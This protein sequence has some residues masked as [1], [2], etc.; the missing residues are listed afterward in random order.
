MSQTIRAQMRASEQLRKEKGSEE[1]RGR[2][3]REGGAAGMDKRHP[4][5]PPNFQVTTFEELYGEK[6]E[7]RSPTFHVSN[8]EASE[9]SQGWREAVEEMKGK[10]EEQMREVKEL[11]KKISQL[12]IESALNKQEIVKREA[13]KT[14]QEVG[15]VMIAIM[16]SKE[17]MREAR[18]KSDAE[19]LTNEVRGKRRGQQME[20]LLEEMRRRNEEEAREREEMRNEIDELR[21]R[22]G[23]RQVQEEQR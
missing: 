11:G 21:T 19:R 12:P 1:R 13:E 4:S 5:A 7:P 16:A 10:V 22:E 14:R 8:R 2:T 18:Q 3:I 15:A 23:K 9:A 17:A 20:I 6:K